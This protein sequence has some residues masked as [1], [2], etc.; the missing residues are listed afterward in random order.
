MNP[1]PPFLCFRPPLF[2]RRP[3]KYVFCCWMMA[4]MG[5]G[6]AA[7]CTRGA[8]RVVLVL[9]APSERTS[10][11]ANGRARRA[12]TTGR[13]RAGGRTARERRR[14]RAT[15]ASDPSSLEGP[16]SGATRGPRA[17]RRLARR[18]WRR[19]RCEFQLGPSGW[20][21][22]A[23]A[24]DSRGGEGR[25]G[26]RTFGA[27]TLWSPRAV[28]AGGRRRFAG[29]GEGAD[30]GSDATSARTKEG[31]DAAGVGVGA[32]AWARRSSGVA[33][34]RVLEGLD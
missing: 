8:A 22:R 17:D 15:R 14:A 31:R 29:G 23:L 28:T 13:W 25:E 33:S 5:A 30:A 32:S 7:P 1:A 3:L 34:V 12:R 19:P 16:P 20:G 11:R 18:L 4:S 10:P 9:V 27:K 26:R 2:P 21:L 6:D 24:R